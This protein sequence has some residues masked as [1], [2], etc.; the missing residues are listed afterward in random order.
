VINVF[1][2]ALVSFQQHSLV[3]MKSILDWRKS[4]LVTVTCG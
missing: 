1:A 3:Q 2:A 4:V